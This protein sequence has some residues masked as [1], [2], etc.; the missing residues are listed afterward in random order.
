MRG[1]PF[2]NGRTKTG[3]RTRGVKNRRTIAAQERLDA[4]DFIEALVATDDGTISPDVRLRAATV[5]AA[6][7]HS[8]P[9]PT[10]TET[11]VA[12]NGYAAPKTV[13]EARQAILDLG[14]LLAKGKISVEAHDALVGGLKAYLGDKAADQ[15]KKL[16][17]LEAFLPREEEPREEE[18]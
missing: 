6:Y 16:D 3:G 2:V 11:F 13:E 7:Q 1:Q 5:L 12:V 8:R 14:L 9:A 10:R 17:E 18:Q 4:L 15:Q